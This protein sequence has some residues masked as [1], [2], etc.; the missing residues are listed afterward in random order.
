NKLPVFLITLVIVLAFGGGVWAALNISHSAADSEP[1]VLGA[2]TRLP[3]PKIHL[4][5]PANFGPVSQI[6]NDVLFSMTMDQLENYLSEKLK[7]PELK[8]AEIV[9][10]R[11]AEL[12]VYLEERNSP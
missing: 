7:S 2:Q 9:A 12:R 4:E 11:K 8:Q 1:Q 5:G 3:S 6:P 10:Q